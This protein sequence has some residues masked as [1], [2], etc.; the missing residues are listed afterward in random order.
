[1]TQSSITTILFDLDGTLIDTVE[2]ILESYRHTVRV[3]GLD[4]VSEQR[5]RQNIGIPLRVQFRQFT[6]D[7]DEIQALIATY[8]EHNMEHHDALVREYPGVCDAVKALHGAGYRLG[9]VTSKMHGGLER[10]LALGGY[11]GLFEVLIGADDVENPKPHAEPVL[12]ALERMEV[13]AECAV[14]VGDS[15]HDMACGHAAGVQ[16]GAALWGPFMREA[17]HPHDPDHWFEQ[18]SDIER[19]FVSGQ[20][21]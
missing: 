4:P 14:F 16:T 6:D 8:M 7:P 9:V 10:G 13:A 21:A 1:M 11:E 20:K 3:H 19:L 2:L 12:K 5:W 17:L 18:P 15:P